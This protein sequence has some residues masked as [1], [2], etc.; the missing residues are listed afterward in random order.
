MAPAPAWVWPLLLA[1]GAASG[2]EVKIGHWNVYWRALS[3]PQGRSAI[4]Q[5]L[6]AAAA[7]GP[8]DFLSLVEAQGQNEGHFPEWLE[9]S[10]ALKAGAGM[11]RL[12]GT[13]GYEVIALLYDERKWSAKYSSVGGMGS[14]RP[15]LLALFSSVAEPERFVWVLNVHTPHWPQVGAYRPGDTLVEAMRNAS[16][17]TG[18][19]V[20]ADP[21]LAV[22]DWNEFGECS[23]PPKVRCANSW[24]RPAAEGMK[25][26]WDYLGEGAMAD[27][28]PFNTTTCCTKWKEG[29]ND[30]R[31]HFDKMF[32]STRS[33][34]VVKPAEFIK[35]AYPGLS[36]ACD[37]P[38]CIGD[39]PPGGVAPSVQ[40]SWHRGWQV[41]YGSKEEVEAYV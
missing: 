16:A 35:Y 37:S 3:D 2:V 21:L 17:A 23:L 41:T 22:G 29:A 15:Y 1:V 12:N 6:D 10:T 31:H 25:P 7:S 13:S 18:R 27:A 33:W 38:A 9:A 20:P 24:Y 14:G 4:V 11:A 34:T 28:V 19:S 30:W 40:G 5:S 36:G 32:Y 39:T 26:L 8:F